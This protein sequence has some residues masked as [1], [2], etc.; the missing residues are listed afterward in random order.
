MLG[1]L[2]QTPRLGG[3]SY[4]NWFIPGL[5]GRARSRCWQ[6]MSGEGFPLAVQWLATMLSVC[7]WGH[8][9]GSSLFS[10]SAQD[11]THLLKSRLHCPA[12]CNFSKYLQFRAPT[13]TKVGDTNFQPTALYQRIKNKL[14]AEKQVKTSPASSMAVLPLMPMFGRPLWVQGEPGLHSKFQTSQ[15]Y[16]VSKR[17]KKT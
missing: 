11:G 12:S 3:L 13:W 16:T 8:R 4:R 14:W 1:L 5:A 9:V 6:D 10:L 17:K 15:G 7:M 2:W